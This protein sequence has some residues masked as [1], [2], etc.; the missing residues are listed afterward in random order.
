MKL[1]VWENVLHDYT[2][3]VMFALAPA[4]EDARKQLLVECSYIPEFDL[5]QEPKMYDMSSP[6]AFVMWGGG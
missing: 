4:V 2:E 1:F 5:S 3:G 6:V